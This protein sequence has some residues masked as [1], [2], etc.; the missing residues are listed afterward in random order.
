MLWR[1]I[2]LWSGYD[3]I[4]VWY[5]YDMVMI[6]YDHD[7]VM[8][9]LWYGYN[10][11]CLWYDM[12]IIWLYLPESTISTYFLY[13]LSSLSWYT[14][15]LFPPVKLR[16]ERDER[17]VRGER[18]MWERCERGVREVWER[19]E[20]EKVWPLSLFPNELLLLWLWLWLCKAWYTQFLLSCGCRN[21]VC[22]L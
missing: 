18:E 15:S 1:M 4:C 3:M 7:V 13:T 12:V 19:R 22:R 16:G 9:W 14:L 5:V 8:I 21:V 20:G 10:M 2:W 17:E 11:T 6:W